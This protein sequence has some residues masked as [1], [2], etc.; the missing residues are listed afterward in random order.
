MATEHQDAV[1]GNDW[2]LFQSRLHPA[3]YMI[4]PPELRGIIWGMVLTPNQT[5]NTTPPL[6]AALR[7]PGNLVLYYEALGAFYANY[8]F[9]LGAYNYW[10]LGNTTA[11]AARTIKSINISLTYVSHF[12]TYHDGLCASC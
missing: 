1:D 7:H 6:I 2:L 3:D 11:T 4:L 5:H 9:F 10:T 12:H 8:S